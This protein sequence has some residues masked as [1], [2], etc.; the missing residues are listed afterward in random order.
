MADDRARKISPFQPKAQ[1]VSLRH[2]GIEHNVDLRFKA[3]VIRRARYL[4]TTI[5]VPDEHKGLYGDRSVPLIDRNY[6][7]FE[8]MADGAPIWKGAVRGHENAISRMQELAAKPENEVRVLHMSSNT[9][10]AAMNVLKS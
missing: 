9:L 5:S 6:D 4:H 7:I 2:L 3:A 8:I 10:I 1:F